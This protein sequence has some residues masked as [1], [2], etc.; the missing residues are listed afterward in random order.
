MTDRTEL[1]VNLSDAT[2]IRRR[3]EQRQRFESAPLALG[4][5]A[6]SIAR[7]R[8]AAH[9]IS[10]GTPIGGGNGSR[11]GPLERLSRCGILRR[12]DLPE[13]FRHDVRGGGGNGRSALRRLRRGG[14]RHHQQT[15]TSC[16]S[17]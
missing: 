10:L 5:I 4:V 2:P 16:S 3:L 6:Q 7:G 8:K 17:G 12:V 11:Q 1:V 14:H 13:S 15:S 9:G